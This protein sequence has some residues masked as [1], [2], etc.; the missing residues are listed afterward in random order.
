MPFQKGQE[1]VAGSGRQA[2]TL[3]KKSRSLEDRCKELN[4]SP[5]D[6]LLDLAQFSDTEKI[7]FAAI[8]ELCAYLYPKRK[9][10]EHF[11]SVNNPYL[12][13]P[14]EKLAALARE[15]LNSVD[16]GSKSREPER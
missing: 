10:I 3:N 12:D 14:L 15:K 11:G 13:M 5:F 4:F 2:G 1:K 6:A 9:A 8:K 16:S 7:R